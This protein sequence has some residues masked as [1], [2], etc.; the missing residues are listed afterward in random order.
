MER[1]DP[2]LA[3][4]PETA[5]DDVASPFNPPL[6]GRQDLLAFEPVPLRHRHDGLTPQK[7][8]EYVE[9]LA[10]TGICARRR[11]ASD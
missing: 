4:S 7:Q 8:R 3:H 1:T 11:P 6:P 9:A 2:R 5:S 10:D